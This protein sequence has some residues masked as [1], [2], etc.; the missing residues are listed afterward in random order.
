MKAEC[1]VEKFKN[2]LSITERITG[3]NLTLPILGAILLIAS[4]KSIKMRATNLNLGI[5]IEIPAKI[6]KEGTIAIR[7]D[8]LNV[9]FSSN[10][11][12]S[13]VVLNEENGNLLV[14]TKNNQSLIKGYPHEDFPTIPGVTGETFFIS[15]KKITEGIKSVYYSAALSEIKPEIA[16]IYIFTEDGELV[17][18]ST[19]S[20][21][22]AEK[23]IKIKNIPDISGILIPYKNA[24]EIV[25]VFSDF[26][27]DVKIEFNKNQ[28]SFSFPSLYLTSRVVD[29]IFP[30]YKQ[31]IPK[32]HTTEVVVL[33]HD[34]INALKV[35]NVFSDKFN[36]ITFMANMKKK[37]FSLI[38]KNSDVGESTTHL[39]AAQ[40]GEDIEISF[41]YKYFIDAFQSV[42]EDSI[43]LQFLGTS[44]AT[45]LKGVGNQS[46]MYLIM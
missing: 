10:T 31:I 13:T 14:S 44:K 36:Q 45:I 8:V 46:F 4:G 25:R 19:D 34:L 22:L 9:L 20:F 26:S 15:V 12:N 43:S 39:D 17:F 11:E 3:K 30:D 23:R 35:A 6:E 41:N 7:G 40:K 27:E 29:G 28:I 1:S 2:A 32:N 18:V 42:P 38:S 37:I 33:K 21:R 24:V 5:E 16:S